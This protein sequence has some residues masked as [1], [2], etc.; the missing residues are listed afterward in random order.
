ML[1]SFC[2]GISATCYGKIL[3]SQNYIVDQSNWQCYQ[4]PKYNPAIL[5]IKFTISFRFYNY[6]KIK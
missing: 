5:P 6:R 2:F 1:S 3:Q 4:H